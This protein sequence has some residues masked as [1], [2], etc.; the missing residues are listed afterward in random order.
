MIYSALID[1]LTEMSKVRFKDPNLTNS[2]SIQS[3]MF[4]NSPNRFIS[5]DSGS[6]STYHFADGIEKIEKIGE[7]NVAFFEVIYNHR[8]IV[9]DMPTSE[10]Y[11]TKMFELL[12]VLF[13]SYPDTIV[14]RGKDPTRFHIYLF[15]EN[16]DY[17][18]ASICI[19]YLNDD[20]LK[21]I[22]SI[23]TDSH[24]AGDFT[25]G[26]SRE[27]I[28]LFTNSIYGASCNTIIRPTSQQILSAKH[29]LYDT[30]SESHYTDNAYV[31]QCAFIMRE[32]HKRGMHND[33]HLEL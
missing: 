15:K 2:L 11:T 13:G 5:F 22:L 12:V 23:L 28:K 33:T 18:F 6:T 30:T 21:L 31:E 29:I 10:V 8:H 20:C 14:F 1:K 16:P 24:A 26:M 25:L 3:D 4:E 9:C 7:D 17:D 19:Q 27:Q 32:M